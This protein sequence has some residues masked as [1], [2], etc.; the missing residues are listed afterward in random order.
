MI[1]DAAQKT[2]ENYIDTLLQS[3][4]EVFLVETKVYPGNNIKVFL[5]ADKGITI[6]KCARLNRLLYKKIE[7]NSLFEDGNF[8]LEVS[9]PG[10]GEPLKL[11]R[12]YKKNTGR[13]I[14]ILLDDES[15]KQGKLVAV[16]DNEII[17]EQKEGK[18]K[19]TTNTETTILFNHIKHTKVLVTF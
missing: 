9:S 7:E 19:N 16:T 14:E 6:E 5:D 1:A 13:T 12:Q 4:E 3:D 8:S 11:L 2:I 17:I 15:K 10:L 18:G